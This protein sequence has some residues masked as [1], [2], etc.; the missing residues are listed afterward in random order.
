MLAERGREPSRWA[1]TIASNYGGACGAKAAGISYTRVLRIWHA[2]GPKPHLVKT[3]LKNASGAVPSK[4]LPNSKLL[5]KNTSTTT[6]L[7]QMPFVWAATA[8]AI[9]E[10]VARG[11]QVLVSAH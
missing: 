10:K 2:H 6:M 4:A 9:L 7:I 5:S 3:S 8:T 1:G 11:R